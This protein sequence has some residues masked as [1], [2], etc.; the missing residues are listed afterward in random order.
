MNSK[1][2][3]RKEKLMYRVLSCASCASCVIVR[4]AELPVLYRLPVSLIASE[5][6]AVRRWM[7][8]NEPGADPR[9]K[10]VSAGASMHSK[11][12]SPRDRPETA[13][14]VK[15]GHRR[16]PETAARASRRLVELT[17]WMIR[18]FMMSSS[19]LGPNETLGASKV[20]AR[21]PTFGAR[22]ESNERSETAE[23]VT[24]DAEFA[25]RRM[26]QP[27]GL[28]GLCARSAT[29]R[30]RKMPT[31]SSDSIALRG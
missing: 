7:P 24:M 4:S 23:P 1:K 17:R 20:S 25:R 8:A 19:V 30:G 27:C 29:R 18:H 11:S 13:R 5:R 22:R 12:G 16:V 14:W 2:D 15:L 28:C 31:G 26:D 9:S 6:R 3:S 10:W 21:A